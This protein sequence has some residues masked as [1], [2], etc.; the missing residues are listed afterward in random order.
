[1]IVS[2]VVKKIHVTEKNKAVIYNSL[3]EITLISTKF[4]FLNQWL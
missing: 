4:A 2:P 3:S 1:M